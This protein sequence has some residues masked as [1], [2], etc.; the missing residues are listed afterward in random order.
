MEEKIEEYKFR[1]MMTKEEREAYLKYGKEY[2]KQALTF[3]DRDVTREEY[4]EFESLLTMAQ[5]VTL[6]KE[7]TGTKETYLLEDMYDDIFD[8]N[9]DVYYGVD[10]NK[11]DS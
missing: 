3:L 10:E 6:Y 7:E 8:R 11:K 1:I 2:G 4:S 9:D 5:V